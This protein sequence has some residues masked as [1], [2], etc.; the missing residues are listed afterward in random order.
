MRPENKL[1]RRRNHTLRP[2]KIKQK[3][4]ANLEAEL[5]RRLRSNEGL[6]RVDLARQ[7]GLAP[8]TIG[9][10]VD[11]LIAEGFLFEGEKAER[12]FGRPPTLLA[13]NPGGGCFI[14]VDFEAHNIMATVVDFSQRQLAQVHKVIR[15]SDSVEQIIAKI[16]LTVEEL[17]DA[18]SHKVLG[19]GVGVPGSIDPKHQVALHYEHIKGWKN[20]LLGAR[21]AKRFNVGVFL[22]HNI[23]S[24]ALAELWFGQGRGCENF[25]CLGIRTGI[26]AG[27]IAGG[28]LLHGENNLAGEIGGWLCPVG[29]IESLASHNGEKTSSCRRWRP[30][31]EIA[32]LPAILSAVTSAMNHRGESKG[33]SDHD[34]ISFEQLLEAVQRHDPAV[35]SVLQDAAEMLGWVVC[36]INALFNPQKIIL[37]GPL[38][39]LG[40]AFLLP[41][42]AA[43]SRFCSE[44]CQQSVVAASELGAFNG[45][46]G[47]AALAL[48][49]WKP[50]R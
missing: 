26:S 47:A 27:I 43:V 25:V 21:L 35:G 31:E 46:L 16:E 2:L 9:G 18:S 48:N 30:L 17:I 23:R 32:S 11:R 22:E 36:Q 7:L 34:T 10:Y 49:Q 14:G 42:K 3:A 28:R 15:A 44:N 29:P 37:A 20:I 5:L 1:R 39:L 41:L 6:S 40:D 38:V 33:G 4:I 19:I 8:S 45:A 13:L 50:K 12:D 24:M